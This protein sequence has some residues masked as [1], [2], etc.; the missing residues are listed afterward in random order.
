MWARIFS[1]IFNIFQD[2]TINADIHRNSMA[3]ILLKEML[4]NYSIHEC[5]LYQIIFV[6]NIY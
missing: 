3:G 2:R 1:E 5:L 4:S 6:A